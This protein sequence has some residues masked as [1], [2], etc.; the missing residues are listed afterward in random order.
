LSDGNEPVQYRN[1]HRVLKIG[2]TG[3]I[4]GDDDVKIGGFGG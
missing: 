2:H 4:S 3:D 1:R